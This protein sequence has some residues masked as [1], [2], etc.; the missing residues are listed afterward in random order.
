MSH[1]ESDLAG[2]S[3][4]P[5]AMRIPARLYVVPVSIALLL[6]LIGI[7][8][9]AAEWLTGSDTVARYSEARHR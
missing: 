5:N 9:T 3:S 8:I 6:L 2:K 7:G 1:T 4:D